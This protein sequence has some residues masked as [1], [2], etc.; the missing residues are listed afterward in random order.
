MPMR[1]LPTALICFAHRVFSLPECAPYAFNAP[2]ASGRKGWG[3]K[4]VEFAIRT[5]F[6]SFA[7]GRHFKVVYRGVSSLPPR[8]IVRPETLVEFASVVGLLDCGGRFQL[9]RRSAFPD[10]ALVLHGDIDNVD[11]PVQTPGVAAAPGVESRVMRPHR[12]GLGIGGRVDHGLWFLGGTGI[13]TP[14]RFL[15]SR[16]ATLSKHELK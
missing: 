13:S 14:S 4:A 9:R 6:A 2:G 11:T 7:G 10:C 12:N 1:V 8:H 15:R 16:N 5:S 3:Q